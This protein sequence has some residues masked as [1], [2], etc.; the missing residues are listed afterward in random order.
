[1]LCDMKR[2]FHPFHLW[3]DYTNGMWRKVSV[4]EEAQYLKHAIEF[5]GNHVLYGK[6]MLFA[7][8]MWPN[9]CEHN[10]TCLEMNRQA[11]IGH[12]A[13]CIAFGCPEYIT[14]SAWHQL[15][16]MQQDLA[17]NQADIAIKIWEENY[18]KDPNWNRCIDSRPAPD[19]M[20]VRHIRE[21]LSVFQRGEGQYGNATFGGG[22][23]QK[24]KENVWPI[25]D[26][27]GKS[28]QA[29]YGSCGRLF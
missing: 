10:L 22:R 29:D 5:T 12:A 14:R 13:V 20:D 19:F 16:Q 9:G 4:K 28:V 15:T 11:W 26:R 24:K 1:M 21:S 23:G 8:E 3:E 25:A 6:Y 17:N 18:A 7:I 27:Y 2:V